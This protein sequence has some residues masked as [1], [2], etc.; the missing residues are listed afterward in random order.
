MHKALVSIP[1]I[2]KKKEKKKKDTDSF[3]ELR[4][5]VCAK[6]QRQFERRHVRDSEQINL[7]EIEDF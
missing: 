3:L 7:A 1:S 4:K 6:Q 5:N 2:N